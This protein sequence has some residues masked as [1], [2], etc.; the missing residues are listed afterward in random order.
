LFHSILVAQA[1]NNDTNNITAVQRNLCSSNRASST[2]SASSTINNQPAIPTQPAAKRAP[3]SSPQSSPRAKSNKKKRRPGVDLSAFEKDTLLEQLNQHHPVQSATGKKGKTNH[4]KAVPKYPS[5]AELVKRCKMEVDEEKAFAVEA[6]F[7]HAAL[8]LVRDGWLDDED[9]SNLSKVD[10]HYEAM[11]TVV[12]MLKHVDFSPLAD[13]RYD[14][15]KQKDIHV[16]RVIMNTACAVYYGLEFGFVVRF[17]GH[18]YTGEHRNLELLKHECEP[19]ISPDDLAQIIRIL[20]KGCPAQLK[21]ELPYAMK[22]RMLRRGNQKSV[23]ENM[24]EV[25]AT[26]NKEEKHCHV[27]PF[28]SFVARFAR[29]AQIMYPK[30]WSSRLARI[31]AWFGTARQSSCLMMLS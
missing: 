30:A 29:G 4:V 5:R 15:T 1:N 14:Y 6:H 3:V 9:L 8:F 13:P 20:S 31:L 10:P 16:D 25:R 22:M 11:V 17:L 2:L 28:L 12:P 19:H 24:D 18:E 7:D 27:V 26:M 23:S 21:Y